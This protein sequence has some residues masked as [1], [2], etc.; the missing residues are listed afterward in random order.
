MQ[1]RHH[2][3]VRLK[4][5][6]K[7]GL[8]FI[9]GPVEKFVAPTKYLLEKMLIVQRRWRQLAWADIEAGASHPAIHAV[10][11]SIRLDSVAQRG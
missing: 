8:S 4:E 11:N 5:F 2:P 1:L 3:F 7:I 10:C 6:S 9:T